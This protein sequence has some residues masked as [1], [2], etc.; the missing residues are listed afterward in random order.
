MRMTLLEELEREKREASERLRRE[1]RERLECALRELLPE[2]IVFVFGSLAQSGR[3]HA[4]SDVDLAIFELPGGISGFSLQSRLE[5]RLGRPV[6]LLLLPEHRLKEKI[7][8]EGE[9]WIV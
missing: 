5:E 2:Q 3:F 4:R 7:Q 8:R 9:M 1:A 6:D